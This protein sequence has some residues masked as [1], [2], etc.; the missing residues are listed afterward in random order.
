MLAGLDSLL[1]L[2]NPGTS[3]AFPAEVPFP[4][5]WEGVSSHCEHPHRPFPAYFHSAK[6]TGAGL[7]EVRVCVKL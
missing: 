1:Q 6:S 3:F 5:S 4:G 2:C 7:W